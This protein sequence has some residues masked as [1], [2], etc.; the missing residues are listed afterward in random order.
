MHFSIICA[1]HDFIEFQP[2]NISIPT[3]KLVAKYKIRGD[4]MLILAW[5][6]EKSSFLLSLSVSKMAECTLLLFKI[7]RFISKTK[8]DTE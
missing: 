6:V 7:S 4:I 8:Q 1:A 3:E 2:S 5:K